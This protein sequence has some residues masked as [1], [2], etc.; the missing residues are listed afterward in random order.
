MF[1]DDPVHITLPSVKGKKVYVCKDN[2]GLGCIKG[3]DCDRVNLL[4]VFKT[5]AS[6]PMRFN[7]ANAEE[8]AQNY[9]LGVSTE[10]AL[11]AVKVFEQL[12]LLSF[13]G[14]NLTVMRGVKTSLDNSPLYNFVNNVSE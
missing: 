14:G 11:F 1:L 2:S 10:Q 5:I 4:T 13:K 6:N 9:D 8:L 3:L 12:N 7:C